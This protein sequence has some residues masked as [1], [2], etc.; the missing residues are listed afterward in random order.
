M[1]Q[2]S[3]RY[4]TEQEPLILAEVEPVR[5]S[6]EERRAIEERARRVRLRVER[7]ISKE[8]SR[9]IRELEPDALMRQSEGPTST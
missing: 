5:M 8:R 6:K 7:N 3:K 4:A 9:P 1:N 2:N